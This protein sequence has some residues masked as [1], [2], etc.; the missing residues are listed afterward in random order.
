MGHVMS[1][2]STRKHPRVAITIGG[3]AD[4]S[5]GVGATADKSIQFDGEILI[6]IL[7]EAY[8]SNNALTRTIS[9]LDAN[10]VTAYSAPAVPDAAN[11]LWNPT[12][13]VA[14]DGLYTV[15]DKQSGVGATAGI[16]YLTLF[17][18]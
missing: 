18:I 14:L 15:R 4:Y 7:L 5:G 17:V 11:T 1:S 12:G 13:G 2:A 6:Q 3:T 10:G 8:Q 9:L 16:D